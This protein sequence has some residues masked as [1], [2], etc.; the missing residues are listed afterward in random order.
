MKAN[1]LTS[2]LSRIFTG[3]FGSGRLVESGDRATVSPAPSPVA[4]PA[5]S[6]VSAIL[7]SPKA[8]TAPIIAVSSNA[9]EILR[10]HRANLAAAVS[11]QGYSSPRAR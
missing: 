4:V 11:T 6:P 8:A 1:P 3:V 5:P 9:S 7:H 10:E 2:R